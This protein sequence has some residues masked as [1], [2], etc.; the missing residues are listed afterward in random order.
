MIRIRLDEATRAELQALRRTALPAVTRDR[1]EMLSLSEGGWSPPRI[2]A[3]PGRY[4]QTV[5]NFLRD[6]QGRGAAALYPG[7]PGPEPDAALLGHLRSLGPH[8]RGCWALD[9]I[10]EYLIS[11]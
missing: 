4:P 5:R 9:L 6:Y 7:K 10:L 8:V 11:A 1:L 2:A 3:H